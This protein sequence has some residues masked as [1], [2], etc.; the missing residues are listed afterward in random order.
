M[1]VI[2]RVFPG[3]GFQCLVFQALV[4][5]RVFQVFFSVRWQPSF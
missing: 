4:A 5:L 2:Q 3:L 1:L